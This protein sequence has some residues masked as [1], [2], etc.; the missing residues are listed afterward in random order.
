M[1]SVN[2]Q[3]NLGKSTD[4]MGEDMA[5]LSSGY[6]INKAAD[7]AAGLAISESMKAKI[8]SMDQAKRNANDGVSLIQI[9]EGSMNEVSN[10]LVR[11][12]ELTTQAAT[13]TIGNTERSY[14]NREYVQLVN[15]IERISN[16]TNF[17]GIP[18]LSGSE[19]TGVDSMFTIHV[20]AGDGMA[21]NTDT[22]R[23]GTEN[24]KVNIEE[25]GL[26]TESEI[27]PVNVEDGF[28]RETAAAKLTVIDGAIEK[29]SSNRAYLGAQ[30]SRLSS[31]INNLGIQVENTK[32][33]HSRIR[34]VDFAEVTAS[35]TQNKILQQAGVS[36]LA[37]ANSTPE[38]ALAL[39]R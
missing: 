38:L 29:I 28:A 26:G 22:I 37:Q 8:R 34:D 3:R 27:G 19:T 12:R 17:N 18:L 16:T 24:M 1:A 13:D 15:E 2:S 35:F 21:E 32:S 30:Q 20:G 39:L 9:A 6:R 11:L 5:K 10:I 4:S 23:I 7:D 14:S 31:S 36:V 25:M 33:A